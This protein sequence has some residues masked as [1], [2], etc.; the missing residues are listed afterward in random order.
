MTRNIHGNLAQKEEHTRKWC[1]HI[2][3]T[4]QKGFTLLLFIIK[5]SKKE[6]WMSVSKSSA[7]PSRQKVY[8]RVTEFARG[9]R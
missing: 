1:W 2:H 4:A 9:R 5:F 3:R 6:Y 8:M 7:L